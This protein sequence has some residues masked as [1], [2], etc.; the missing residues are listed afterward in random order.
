M[1]LLRFFEQTMRWRVPVH[2]RAW[3]RDHVDPRHALDR[4]H[5]VH[6]MWLSS[7]CTDPSTVVPRIDVRAQYAC[8]QY[9]GDDVGAARALLEATTALRWALLETR[10][11]ESLDQAWCARQTQ[12]LGVTQYCLYALPP[13]HVRGTA[14][15]AFAVRELRWA[16]ALD[17]LAGPALRH[18]ERTPKQRHIDGPRYVYAVDHVQSGRSLGSFASVGVA[19]EFAAR[20][21]DWLAD[22]RDSMPPSRVLD[23]Y[24]GEPP[25]PEAPSWPA[26]PHW[27]LALLRQRDH[28]EAVRHA[29]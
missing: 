26:E 2:T 20:H 3:A 12:G 27:R 6:L 23:R 14:V 7:Q 21:D 25:H 11:W 24:R 22:R 15:G 17:V 29:G 9:D 5:P 4:A 16:D 10:W 1:N 19:F 8:T 18:R 28:G 13:V